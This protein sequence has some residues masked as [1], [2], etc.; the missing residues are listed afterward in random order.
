MHFIHPE[1][2]YGL[3]LLIIPV[4][5]HLFQLR[6]FKKEKFTNVKFLKKAVL[7]TRKS[8]Q[9]KKWLI[10]TIRCL[11]LAC[12]VIAFAQPYFPASEENIQAQETVV[13]LD[14]S[15]SMQA[16]G[17]NGILLRRSIQELLE[18]S[19]DD[20]SISLFTNDSEFKGTDPETLRKELQ[21]L[22]FS[23]RQLDWNAISLKAG[24]FF[25]E[26]E[27]TLKNLVMISD[28]QE[29]EAGEPLKPEGDFQ[30]HLVELKPENR[31]N[32]SI[33]TAYISEKTLDKTEL[34]V[35]ISTSNALEQEVSIS[36]Y[37]GSKLLAKRSVSSQ[38]ENL[39]KTSFE[40]PSGAI[41][42]GR[43]EIEDSGLEF[44]N[45]LYFSINK[46]QPIMVAV[47]G[48][49]DIAFLERIYR[50]PEFSFSNFTPEQIDYNLLSQADL[51]IL[52]ELK[53]ISASLNSTLLELA[54]KDVFMT[55][56]PSEEIQLESYHSLLK[57]LGLPAIEEKVG[58]EKLITEIAY[59]HPLFKEVFEE[60][61]ENFQYPKVKSYYRTSRQAE[62][63][64][65]YEN[66]DAFL[67]RNGNAFL[68]TAALNQENSDFQNAPL[69]VPT[70]Y[71][72]GNL[73]LTP[74][75]LYY[76]LGEP[77]EVDVD[78][79]LGRDE[80]LNL[81]SPGFSFIPLQQSF[82]N[83][84]VIRLEEEPENPGH[85]EIRRDSLS[86]KNISFNVDREES[87]MKYLDLESMEGVEVAS[88]I[89]SAFQFVE[90]QTEIDSLWKWFVIFALFLLVTEMLILKFI[91]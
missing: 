52:Y 14:N 11:L 79:S 88:T 18:A 78:V 65:G 75:P 58:Q 42:R 40:L 24:N 53:Q 2:L 50:G 67:L 83:K 46:P 38:E 31:N 64:L 90:R 5:V 71:N 33:D 51:I 27:G 91:K 7:K 63:V 30:Y 61:V 54:N 57:G 25:S 37:D 48:E 23:A 43:I 26:N 1:Y 86:L 74:T 29:R 84:V 4:L 81:V 36:I 68:F 62:N 16:R 47:I 6:R 49:G 76:L 89:P 56:I 39:I 45:N 21:Q 28:F 17:A 10:L 55:I 59:K 70:F 9:I 13:Y 34:T 32:L 12:L 87:R 82:P 44:D 41:E 8:S 60:R 19:P 15:Y 85:F 69:I 73:A 20:G 80:I 22:D 72:F 77:Q 66:G 35:G 3:F